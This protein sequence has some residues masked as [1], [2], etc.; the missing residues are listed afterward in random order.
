MKAGDL[1]G[2]GSTLISMMC[3]CVCACAHWHSN[4][5]ICVCIWSQMSTLGPDSVGGCMVQ[6]MHPWMPEEDIGCPTL[7]TFRLIPLR[8]CLY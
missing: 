7:I 8:Q 6:C 3:V 2:S 5:F 4:G 1:T